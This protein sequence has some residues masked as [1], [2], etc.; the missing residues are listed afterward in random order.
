MLNDKAFID[1]LSNLDIK[2]PKYGQ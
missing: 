1:L 2:P